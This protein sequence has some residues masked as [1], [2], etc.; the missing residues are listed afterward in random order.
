MNINMR[1][2]N[3]KMYISIQSVAK[4]FGWSDCKMKSKIRDYN[5]YTPR[6][7]KRINIMYDVDGDWLEHRDMVKF[8]EYTI[9]DSY[10]STDKLRKFL[11][12]IRRCNNPT[13]KRK[14]TLTQTNKNAIAAE[15]EWKCGVCKNILT[16]SFEVH[17]IQEFSKGG[18]DS[19]ENLVALCR[20]CH[21]D[22][23]IKS[24]MKPLDGYT[25]KNV[26]NDNFV[27]LTREDDEVDKK[28]SKYFRVKREPSSNN[29][30]ERFRK[31]QRT[32]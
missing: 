31:R 13:E 11:M 17:H 24:A 16:V 19:R 26:Q 21:G 18:T 27:D 7:I 6:R 9:S 23:T 3:G 5:N 25:P 28:T 22:I 2:C 20:N 32:R 10:S 14:R 4:V 8:T 15:Q 12:E 29:L 1:M 30:F